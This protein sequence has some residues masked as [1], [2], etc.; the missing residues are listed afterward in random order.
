MNIL[1]ASLT[2]LEFIERGGIDGLLR[3]IFLLRVAFAIAVAV[4]VIQTIR[5]CRTR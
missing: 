5:L 2:G 4:S 1:L 3:E